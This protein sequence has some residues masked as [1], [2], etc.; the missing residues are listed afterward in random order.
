MTAFPMAGF[1][2]GRPSRLALADVP[3]LAWTLIASFCIA[4]A[5]YVYNSLEGLHGDRHNDRVA[6]HPLVSGRV[7][8]PVMR[9]LM[10]ALAVFG[11]A[12]F[13]HF[14]TM[15]RVRTSGVRFMSAER[16]TEQK[17]CGTP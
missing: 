12:G 2:L 9:V 15:A 16:V 3:D 17:I 14:G 11:V 4:G 8:E 6:D 7:T 5:A 13:A 10:G 1:V